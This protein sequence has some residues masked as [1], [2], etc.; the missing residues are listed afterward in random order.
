MNYNGNGKG[1]W[2]F[3][4]LHDTP[5]IR[6]QSAVSRAQ[7]VDHKLRELRGIIPTWCYDYSYFQVSELLQFS[8]R[9]I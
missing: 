3:R 5:T 8:H 1:R 2:H 6:Y 4:F 7:A 9:Y